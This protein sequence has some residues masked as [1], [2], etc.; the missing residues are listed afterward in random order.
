MR[1]SWDHTGVAPRCWST[2]MDEL[3]I[4]L[5]AAVAT[6]FVVWPLTVI[7]RFVERTYEGMVILMKSQKEIIE[8]LSAMADQTEG[9][10]GKYLEHAVK[11]A[12]E[13]EKVK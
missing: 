11:K 9:E 8:T 3:R 6:V 12:A 10:P 2:A 5:C 1:T 4:V 13:R 7:H